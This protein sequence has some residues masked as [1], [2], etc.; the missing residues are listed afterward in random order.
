MSKK[1][2]RSSYKIVGEAQ[3]ALRELRI[4]KGW[5]LAQAAEPLGIKSKGMGHIENGSVGL[6]DERVREILEKWELTY[7]DF[8]S[9]KKLVKDGIRNRSHRAIVRTVLSNKDRRSYQKIIT[10]E[11]RVLKILRQ[12]KKLSQAKA[13]SLCGYSRPTIGHIEQGRIEIDRERIE[14]IVR[15]YGFDVREFDQMMS[16]EVLRDELLTKC[17]QRIESLS[18][19][20]LRLI[21]SLLEAKMI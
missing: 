4:Q 12:M 2:K 8:V 11:V 10:K 1:K 3:L 7:F 6:T 21:N 13:S 14:H 5:S 15:A 20:K 16:E 9:A 18:P 19:E 17:V